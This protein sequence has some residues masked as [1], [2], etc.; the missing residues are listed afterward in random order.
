MDAG[1]TIRSYAGSNE[2]LTSRGRQESR[3][4]VSV[5]GGFSIG[6]EVRVGGVDLLHTSTISDFVVRRSGAF[7]AQTSFSNPLGSL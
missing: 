7:V 6:S 5:R 1:G 4:R 2:G 3:R